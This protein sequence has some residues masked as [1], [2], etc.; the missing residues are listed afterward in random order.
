MKA[1]KDYSQKTLYEEL[2]ELYVDHNEGLEN[3]PVLHLS[4]AYEA[5]LE[6]AKEAKRKRIRSMH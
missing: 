4:E 1:P 5:I 6:R 2:R 3:P